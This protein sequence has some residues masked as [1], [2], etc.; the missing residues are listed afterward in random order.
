MKCLQYLPRYSAVS[1]ACLLFNN[2]LLIALDAL[3]LH[4]ILSVT[5]SVLVMIPMGFFLQSRLTFAVGTGWPSFSRY[6]VAL[7]GNLPLAW[8]LMWLIRDKA[9]VPM[10]LAAPLISAI[11][12]A[13]NFVGSHWA[14]TK[15]K[16]IERHLS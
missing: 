13:I 8:A 7:I 5:I 1:V 6:A 11:A 14:L 3:G 2:L 12:F 9:G 15:H 16:P 4:Y 10:L